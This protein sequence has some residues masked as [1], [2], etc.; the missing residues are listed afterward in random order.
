[1]ELQE[2]FTLTP[3]GLGAC[4][5]GWPSLKGGLSAQGAPQDLGSL[6]LVPS[7]WGVPGTGSRLQRANHVGSRWPQPSPALKK[8]GVRQEEQPEHRQGSRAG[9]CV[10][11]ELRG[12]E[13]LT[14]P[15][16]VEHLAYPLVVSRDLYGEI[17]IEAGLDRTKEGQGRPVVLS[18]CVGRGE[19]VRPSLRS[20]TAACTPWPNLRPRVPG[21]APAS[22]ARGLYGYGEGWEKVTGPTPR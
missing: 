2:S 3:R 8:A 22:G 6:Q 13:R 15:E 17:L 12:Q 19:E 9:R 14:H 1:M 18:H 4:S 10:T 16:V 21:K 7:Y 20:G 5:E 11:L